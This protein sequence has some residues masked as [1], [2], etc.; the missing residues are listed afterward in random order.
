M[1]QI[2]SHLGELARE[3]SSRVGE[4]G[5]RLADLAREFLSGSGELGRI[6]GAQRHGRRLRAA[7]SFFQLT[8]RKAE[9]R[10]G[11]VKALADIRQRSSDFLARR[12]FDKFT[13]GGIGLA[14]QMI[15]GG[16][17]LQIAVAGS[18]AP[19]VRRYEL[20]NLGEGAVG[21]AWP[22]DAKLLAHPLERAPW[23]AKKIIPVDHSPAYTPR[24]RLCVQHV[25]QPDE[26][27]K[28]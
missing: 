19:H 28:A 20:V 11:A 4:L 13:N 1:A 23:I 22:N 14:N 27:T 21:P 16:M 26:A 18:L 25:A 6:F 15:H 24:S 3:L 8:H 12:I 17:H 5:R 7:A 9:N 10:C 2:P